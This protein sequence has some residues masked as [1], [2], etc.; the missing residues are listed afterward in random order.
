MFPV[1]T[2]IFYHVGTYGTARRV[3]DNNSLFINKTIKNSHKKLK[4][5]DCCICSL[6]ILLRKTTHGI[7]SINKNL[8]NVSKDF[9]YS[10]LKTTSFCS[11]S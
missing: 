8:V 3:F 2:K 4:S 7:F 1:I 11:F 10:I 9:I 6:K 5:L